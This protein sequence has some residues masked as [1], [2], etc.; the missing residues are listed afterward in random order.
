[1]LGLVPCETVY[2]PPYFHSLHDVIYLPCL[3]SILPTSPTASRHVRLLNQENLVDLFLCDLPLSLSPPLLL[4]SLFW[5]G[6]ASVCPVP[7]YSPRALR[8]LSLTALPRP[9]V[10]SAALGDRDSLR[11]Y[12]CSTYLIPFFPVQLGLSSCCA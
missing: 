7:T 10:F 5:S 6:A 1:M 11:R 4:S 9:R 2:H 3:L 12:Y 8:S